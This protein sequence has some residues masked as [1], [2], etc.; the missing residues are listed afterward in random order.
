MLSAILI[1][2]I[3]FFIFSN[4]F[5][6]RIDLSVFDY[7]SVVK[8]SESDYFAA[9]IGNVKDLE[10]SASSFAVLE[11][12]GNNFILEKNPDEVWPI[13]SI[14]KLMS[15]FVLLDDLNI[16]LDDVYKIKAE[17]RR[18]GGRDYLFVGDEVKN[19]DLLAL[20][21]IASDNTAISALISSAGFSEDEFVVLMNEKAK[22][23]GM[24]KTFFSDATGLSSKNVSTAREVAILVKET[25]SIEEIYKLAS[26]YEYQV[27]T[28][29]GRAKDI[30]STNELLNYNN[31]SIKVI[32]G[33]TGYN[34]SS[35][36][37]LGLKFL[38][39]DNQEFI[40]VVLNSSSF[41]NRFADTRKIF[42]N[43]YSFYN[44]LN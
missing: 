33:K 25:L 12:A 2:L 6:G 39:E 3:S 27:I 31:N 19:I 26:K 4:D 17:D 35:G 32:G 5:L 7:G 11:L 30:I 36:Y 13:A 41:K 40:S 44:N 22:S 16:A 14:S 1:H 8:L 29:K 15:V 37:C 24:S 10:I 9:R 38:F 21:I 18:L 34:D 43:I 23:L 20:S 42:E 28:Q